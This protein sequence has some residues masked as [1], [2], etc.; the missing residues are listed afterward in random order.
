[1]NTSGTPD[2]VWRIATAAGES[3]LATVD[4]HSWGTFRDIGKVRVGVK[5]CAD[6]VFIRNDWQ[7]M[8]AAICPE[9]LKP[10]TTHHI[11]RR[12]RSLSTDRP[13][14]ILYP[15][16]VIRGRRQPICLARYPRSQAYFEIHRSALESRRYVIEAGREWYEIWVPQD[17]NAWEKPKLVFRD[18]AEK[19][20][21][22]IDL[23]GSVVNG[24]CYWLTSQNPNQTNLLW[25]AVAVGNSTFI[26]RFY[27]LRFH[28]KLYAGRRRFITQYVEQFPLPDPNESVAKSIVTLAKRIYKHTPAPETEKL[29]EDL[30]TMVW[31]A[32]TGGKST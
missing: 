4:T 18:I 10:L 21:F 15:H 24:D 11:A 26:E 12:F 27:D 7:D 19:P 9:L 22:W 13:N 14:Q 30:D 2:G 6:K 31:K 16:E 25:L 8:P 5:T 1:M 3:W 20:T 17:P 29:Y 28:N 32:L 23:A